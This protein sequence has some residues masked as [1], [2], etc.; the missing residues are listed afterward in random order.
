MTALP[1]GAELNRR[2]GK[3]LGWRDHKLSQS[4]KMFGPLGD[5]R[6]HTT[7]KNWLPSTNV[8]VA[9]SAAERAKDD[10]RIENY[11]LFSGDWNS[12]G[13]RPSALVTWGEKREVEMDG[14]TLAHALS[15]ALCAALEVEK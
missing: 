13:D 15:L 12:A 11:A 9:I 4:I 5:Y 3:A 2:L 8:A 10:G 1:P 6:G 14:E 7:D